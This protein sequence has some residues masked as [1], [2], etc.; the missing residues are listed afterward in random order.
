MST[1]QRSSQKNH[2]HEDNIIQEE[3][4]TGKTEKRKMNELKRM[5][6]MKRMG[7]LELEVKVNSGCWELRYD[8]EVEEMKMGK[9]KE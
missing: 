5:K 4:V 8:T 6:R 9:E 3:E 2:K 7:K 1:K